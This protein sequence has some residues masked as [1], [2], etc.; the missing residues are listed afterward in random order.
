[1]DVLQ[2]IKGID[3]FMTVA[4]PIVEAVAPKLNESMK[5]F[6]EKMLELSEKYPSITEFAKVIDKAADILG[7][8]LYVLGIKAEPADVMGVKASQAE[9]GI[10]EFDSIEA[11]IDYLREEIKLDKEKF[12]SLSTDERIAY[13]VTGLALEG[14]AIGEKLGMEI[15]ADI[16]EMVAKISE[17]GKLV[18]ET[19]E[20]LSMALNLKNDGITNLSD[21]SDCIKGTGNSDRLK[22]GEMLLKELN[23]LNPNEGA[24]IFNEIIDEVRE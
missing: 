17:I 6:A 21:I 1:M 12:D 24:K 22:T 7:D 10:D 19:K 18:V 4:K 16:V 11:Y 15:P 3:T 9:K 23:V 8:A 14:G 2:I 20:L 13:S 5:C